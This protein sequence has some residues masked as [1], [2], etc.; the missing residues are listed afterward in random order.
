MTQRW[1]WMVVC[2]S[3]VLS[4][5]CERSPAPPRKVPDRP[6]PPVRNVVPPPP[7]FTVTRGDREGLD[8]VTVENAKVRVTFLPAAGGRVYE[9]T[10]K[11]SGHNQFWNNP[12]VPAPDN[13]PRYHAYGGLDD[14]LD[15]DGGDTSP[16]R[17]PL[18]PFTCEVVES[19]DNVIVSL[20]Y[21]TPTWRL[22]R[23]HVLYP[24]ATRL[25][26]R[27][28]VTNL[29]ETPRELGPRPHPVFAVG[30]DADNADYMITPVGAAVLTHRYAAPFSRD[31][32]IP[33]G[34]WAGVVDT[35]QGE[36]VVITFDRDEVDEINLWL[37]RSS[38]NV[39]P[40]R[41]PRLLKRGES[42]TMTFD[43]FILSDDDLAA[44]ALK[45]PAPEG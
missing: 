18:A 37:A 27:E 36:A 28:V 14:H 13:V 43:M 42:A 40:V 22:S 21:E 17:L 4:A 19:D 26:T 15:L 33:A 44:E 23:M 7:V 39:E 1:W 11:R 25:H 30:G 6:A 31:V 9:Y 29:D 35:A 5:G 10:L 24:D 34:T 32:P 45:L 8:T 38:Y 20:T 41:A 16:K 2:V 12:D 3:V